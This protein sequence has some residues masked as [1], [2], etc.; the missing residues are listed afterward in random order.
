MSTWAVFRTGAKFRRGRDSIFQVRVK[1]AAGEPC[2]FHLR[3]SQKLRPN[4]SHKAEKKRKTKMVIGVSWKIKYF[5]L[6]HAICLLL[7]YYRFHR[8]L[9][10][11]A[12]LF[13][14]TAT[15]PKRQANLAQPSMPSL[16]QRSRNPCDRYIQTHYSCSDIISCNKHG[17]LV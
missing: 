11:T 10:I 9:V 5:L 13:L 14:L 7:M 8:C 12:E 15:K 1:A 16:P 6:T 4:H 3:N 2:P 17:S